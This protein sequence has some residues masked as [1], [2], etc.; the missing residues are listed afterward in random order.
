MSA[1]IEFTSNMKVINIGR[2][3]GQYFKPRSNLTETRGDIILPAYQGDGINSIDFR[4]SKRIPDPDNLIKAYH[5]SAAT[6]NLIRSL[7][8]SGFTDIKQIQLWSRDLL[9]NSPFSSV[10]ASTV[11]K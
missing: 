2:I 4:D 8:M 6:M 3:A 7:I 9:N 1:I 5:H 11:S 10:I